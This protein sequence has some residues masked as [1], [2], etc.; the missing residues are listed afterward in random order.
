[1]V[2]YQRL[3]PFEKVT[4]RPGLYC[5][6]SVLYLGDYQGEGTLGCARPTVIVSEHGFESDG[7]EDSASDS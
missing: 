6:T 4:G 7:V 3:R 1:M 5:L 2:P